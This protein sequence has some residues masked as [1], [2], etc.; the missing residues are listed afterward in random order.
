MS[1]D[2]HDTGFPEPRAVASGCQQKRKIPAQALARGAA[3]VVAAFLLAH[4]PSLWAQ[5]KASAPKL[6]IKSTAFKHNGFIPTQYTCDGSDVSPALSWAEP[7]AGTE[8]FALIMDD[9]DAPMGTFVHWVVYNLPATARQLPERVP[10]N[11]EVQGGFQGV[12]DFPK[13]GY[14]G[15]CPPPGK[16][17]RY[18][19]KLYALD[20]K[21]DLK[22]EVKKRDIEAALKGHVLAHAELIGRYGR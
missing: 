18:F 13:T 16:P 12:N 9:P 7:P 22:G 1:H 19:F 5:Q 4:L 11:S 8:S 14:G 15:P 21:L 6:E 2:A 3:V 20:S 17:H 10:G